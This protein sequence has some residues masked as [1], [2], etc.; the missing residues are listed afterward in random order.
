MA[1]FLDDV[2]SDEDDNDAEMKMNG[3]VWIPGEYHVNLQTSLH[4]I[5]IVTSVRRTSL[6]SKD[7][8][9]IASQ[10]RERK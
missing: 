3:R 10:I 1:D 4:N 6:T 7:L 5:M 8:S 9:A 2:D